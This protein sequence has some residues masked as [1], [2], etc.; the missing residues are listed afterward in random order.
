[1]K[2]FLS[3]TLP[4]SIWQLRGVMRSLWVATKRT[5][6]RAWNICVRACVRASF[7]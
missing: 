4:R 2:L 7:L 1:M 6:L 3:L 5:S